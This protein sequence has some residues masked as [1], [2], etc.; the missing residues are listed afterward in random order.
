MCP[1]ALR[2]KAEGYKPEPGTVVESV[3]S[4]LSWK[5]CVVSHTFTVVDEEDEDET[6]T[7][8]SAVNQDS[9]LNH[10]LSQ[11]ND[12]DE[13]R[14]CQSAVLALFGETPF[15]W[16]QQQLLLAEKQMRYERFHCFDFEEIDWKKWAKARFFHWV[17][18][19]KHP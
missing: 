1:S 8:M 12:P 5:P 4:S 19:S 17:G 15:Y 6:V 14:P 18:H 11:G 9:R 2:Q 3:D 10:A 13:V 16:M 7:V